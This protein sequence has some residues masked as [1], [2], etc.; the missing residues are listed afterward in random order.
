MA[1]NEEIVDRVDEVLKLHFRQKPIEEIA[2]K[3][4]IGRATA[5]RDLQ[6]GLRQ[7]RAKQIDEYEAFQFVAE[8]RHVFE[9]ARAEALELAATALDSEVRVSAIKTV[10]SVQQA[11]V[12]LNQEIGAL[13]KT[14]GTVT[15]EERRRSPF[16]PSGASPVTP[17][18]DLTERTLSTAD[19]IALHEEI[20]G[21]L[22]PEERRRVMAL[23]QESPWPSRT[24]R[25][26]L[27]EPR[28]PD[29]GAGGRVLSSDS[30]GSVDGESDGGQ[31]PELLDPPPR[32]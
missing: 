27:P 7:L 20:F 18:S 25:R 19:V 1:T 17:P 28:S 30:P 32:E 15:V 26:S 24:P 6:R 22:P 31:D 21:A 14:L 10:V 5:Y 9:R 29:A 13:P 3:L 8:T 16:T 11:L 2:R 23:G 4:G 12:K